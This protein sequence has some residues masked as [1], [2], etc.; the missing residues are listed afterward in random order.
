MT[1]GPAEAAMYWRRPPC[2]DSL[3]CG[4][5][6]A[7][8]PGQNLPADAFKLMSGSAGAYW[9]GGTRD[10]PM[11]HAP[12]SLGWPS[13]TPWRPSQ[14]ASAPSWREARK[15]S[16]P[17]PAGLGRENEPVPL[18]RKQAGRASS[19]WWTPNG[20][21]RHIYPRQRRLHG[22]TKLRPPGRRQR[23]PSAYVRRSTSLQGRS[24]GGKTVGE[25]RAATGKTTGKY[26]SSRARVERG[27]THEKGVN[28]LK[29][30]NCPCLKCM[31]FQP[32]ASIIHRGPAPSRMAPNSSVRGHPANEPF[33]PRP[34]TG[35]IAR[36]PRLPLAGR[37]GPVFFGPRTTEIL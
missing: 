19:S 17:T 37:R 5:A 30:M 36:V 22:V 28:A 24:T 10:R 34:C 29:P 25:D 9:R 12:L 8:I 27:N 20:L 35:S 15:G 4:P 1:R 2:Q 3:A 31:I 21:G 14:G 18:T 33:G 6:L 13:R 32:W 23:L 11:L 16:R 7:D 26:C